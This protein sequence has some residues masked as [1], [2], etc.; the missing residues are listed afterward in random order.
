M[1]F[2]TNSNTTGICLLDRMEMLRRVACCGITVSI[3]DKMDKMVRAGRYFHP[4]LLLRQCLQICLYRS[5]PGRRNK[6]Y[7]G[8]RP[9]SNRNSSKGGLRHKV[10]LRAIEFREMGG[11]V[12]LEDRVGWLIRC[13][14]C[15]AGLVA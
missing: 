11:K 6:E 12:G 13:R 4:I 10:G 15:V 2:G 7:R 14:W 5:R 3:M 1:T 8:H 9:N